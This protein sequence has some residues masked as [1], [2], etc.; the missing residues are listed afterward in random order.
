LSRPATHAYDLSALS[1]ALYQRGG[2]GGTACGRTLL[3]RTGVA[4]RENGLKPEADAFLRR[5][6]FAPS[7]T[8]DDFL[9]RANAANERRAHARGVGNAHS[10]S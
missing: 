1:R 9:D 10:P 3:A 4:L 7:F 5:A 2:K 8:D 6:L